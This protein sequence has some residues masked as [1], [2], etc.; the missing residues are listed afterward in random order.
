RP[1][2]KMMDASRVRGDFAGVLDVVRD[3]GEPVV[4]VRYGRP[5]AAL[6]P[7]SRLT[8]RELRAL[9][10]ASPP[11]RDRAGEARSRRAR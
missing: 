9:N 6:V 2:M 11:P 1:R 4:V 5:L 8:P 10:R 7:L 3:G